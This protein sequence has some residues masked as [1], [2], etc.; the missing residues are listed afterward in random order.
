[1]SFLFSVVLYFCETICLNFAIFCKTTAKFEWLFH[2][3]NAIDDELFL[4]V[5]IKETQLNGKKKLFPFL[6]CTISL[7]NENFSLELPFVTM[8]KQWNKIKRKRKEHAKENCDEF[9]NEVFYSQQLKIAGSNR[10]RSHSRSHTIDIFSY[11][12]SSKFST[13]F[14][15]LLR[16]YTNLQ[17]VLGNIVIL[18]YF[19]TIPILGSTIL[20]TIQSSS[21][22]NGIVDPDPWS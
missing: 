3:L 15:L 21:T 5:E 9:W 20:K 13:L 18:I 14:R 12:D 1:M 6:I 8:I 11:Y 2:V 10:N 7:W 22:E 17:P 19:E 4:D 16:A